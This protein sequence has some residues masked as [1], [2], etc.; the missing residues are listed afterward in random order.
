[1]VDWALKINY[2]SISIIYLPTYLPIHPSI[3]LPISLPIY[4]SIYLSTYLSIHLPIHPTTCISISLPT[5]PSIHLPI[6]PSTYLHIHLSTYPPTHPPTYPSIYISIHLSRQV[7]RA[8]VRG[9]ACTRRCWDWP[10]AG[11]TSWAA[12]TAP[13]SARSAGVMRRVT[14]GT[15]PP[16]RAAKTAAEPSVPRVAGTD[17]GAGSVISPDPGRRDVS[18]WVYLFIY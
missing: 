12:A 2:L 14:S 13:L 9:P 16:A 3:Y 17:R 4:L 18:R 5:H 10:S 6:H 8:A 7:R 15:G 1:M 11:T